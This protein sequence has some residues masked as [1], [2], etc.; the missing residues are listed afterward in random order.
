MDCP[1]LSG[2]HLK[3]CRSTSDLLSH[4]VFS[5]DEYCKGPWFRLCPWFRQQQFNVSS[6]ADTETAS[7]SCRE[8]TPCDALRKWVGNR[9]GQGF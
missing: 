4:T 3:P 5:S 2:K 8:L 7:I 1:L 9:R 6:S